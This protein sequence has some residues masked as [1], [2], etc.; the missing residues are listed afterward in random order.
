MKEAPLK[1]INPFTLAKQGTEL[2]GRVDLAAMQALTLLLS[3]AEGEA[4]YELNF[5]Q[6]EGKQVL[7]DGN[8]SAEVPLL[9]Q[10]C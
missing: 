2:K 7:I 10:R 6:R 3:R 8:I 4:S 9:C 1:F 5:S